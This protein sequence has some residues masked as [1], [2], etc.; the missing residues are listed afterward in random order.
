MRRLRDRLARTVTSGVWSVCQIEAA[1]RSE[2]LEDAQLRSIF[3]TRY[4]QR[5]QIKTAGLPVTGP[6]AAWSPG[7]VPSSAYPDT[8][9]N[10]QGWNEGFQFNVSPID[11]EWRESS[12]SPTRESNYCS[13][14][15]ERVAL[16]VS[17]SATGF[18]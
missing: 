18:L 1:D 5:V 15:D 11:T 17:S 9:Q 7:S 6:I 14:A 16:T 10:Q 2:Y 8:Q 3:L 4:R 12:L 13:A